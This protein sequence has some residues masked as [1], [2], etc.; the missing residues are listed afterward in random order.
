MQNGIEVPSRQ[1][2]ADLALAD[3]TLRHC[4]DVRAASKMMTYEDML[5]MAVKEMHGAKMRWVEACLKAA[6]PFDVNGEL[7]G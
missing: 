7:D 2:I 4:F 3:L 5:R 6:L 1:D